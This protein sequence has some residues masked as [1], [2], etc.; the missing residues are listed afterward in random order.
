VVAVVVLGTI[1]IQQVLVVL[2]VAQMELDLLTPR[3]TEL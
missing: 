3:E 1:L 2:A